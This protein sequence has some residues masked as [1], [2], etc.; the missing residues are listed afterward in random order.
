MWD[1]FVCHAS[2]DKEPVARPLAH[3]LESFGVRV[4]LDER[5]LRVGDSLRHGID[6]GLAHSQ[7]GV[8]ILSPA[9]FGKNWTQAELGALFSKES[10]DRR[11]VLPV[12]YKI[13]VEEVRRHSPLLADRV[14]ARWDEGEDA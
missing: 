5:A 14:A 7:F 12:W 4:W 1:V 10:S 13:T 3:R 11:V 9:F 2:E 8:V 6:D